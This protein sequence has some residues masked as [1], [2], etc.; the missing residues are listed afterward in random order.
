MNN[1]LRLSTL[2]LLVINGS[3]GLAQSPCDL[4]PNPGPCFAAIPAYYFNQDTQSCAEFTWGGCG[5]V[6]PFWTL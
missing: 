5:G 2:I 6:V 4:E 1:I 3:L